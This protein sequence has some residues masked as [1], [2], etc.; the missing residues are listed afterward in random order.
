ML[1]IHIIA[2][3]TLKEK[4]FTDAVAEYVKR[5]SK[6]CK[7]EI[8]QI[9]ES[10]PQKECADIREKLKAQPKAHVFLC[11]INGRLVSSE[12]LASE[13]GGLTQTTSCVTFVVG[14]SDGVGANLDDVINERVSFGRV[15][16]PHQLFRVVL[17]E[18][19]YRAFTIQSG[20]K[21]HK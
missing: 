8:V 21:Y 3:G 16:L 10:T 13:L 19:I 11:D 18:Q 12:A 2:V 14:G 6:Y 4:Y 15:T 1:H 7:L 17:V 20:E 5:L 9:K